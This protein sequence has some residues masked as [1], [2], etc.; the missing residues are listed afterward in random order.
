MENFRQL[1]NKPV[2]MDLHVKSIRVPREGP[3]RDFAVFCGID[4]RGES[5]VCTGIFPGLSVGLPVRVNGTYQLHRDRASRIE[6]LEI[7]ANGCTFLQFTSLSEIRQYL[8]GFGIPGCGPKTIDRI[9]EEY[10]ID[11]VREITNAPDRFVERNIQGVSIRARESMRDSVTDSFYIHDAY[12][13][14]LR[15]GFGEKTAA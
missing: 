8:I 11:T 10:G 3:V 4:S 2:T 13:F 9:I 15:K 1:V 5:V 12:S 7:K 6:T 14:L